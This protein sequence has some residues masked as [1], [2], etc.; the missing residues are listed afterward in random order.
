MAPNSS[1]WAYDIL[2]AS[3]PL[4][5][6]STEPLT[7]NLGLALWGMDPII[8]ANFALIDEN[9][10]GGGGTSVYVNGSIVNNPN[11]NGTIPAA[12]SG[13]TNVTW[14][15]DGSGNVSAYL[16]ALILNPSGSQT[17]NDSPTSSF[18]EQ[19]IITRTGYPTEQLYLNGGYIQ[20]H[21]AYA[22]GAAF[23]S[24]SN[25]NFR[26]P[27]ITGAR[28]RG[29]QSSPS[30]IQSGDTIM[31][32]NTSGYAGTDY[33]GP[34]GSEGSPAFSLLVQA[35]ENWSNSAQ[36]SVVSIYT[37]AKGQQGEEPVLTLMCNTSPLRWCVGVNDIAPSS[38]FS[39]SNYDGGP[40]SAAI[41]YASGHSSPSNSL[42]VAGTVRADLGFTISGTAGSGD[43]LRGN[44]TAFVSSAIQIGDLP[45]SGSW[46]FAGT[47][48]GNFSITGNVTISGELIDGSGSAGTNGQIISSTG[49]A[50]KWINAPS[51]SSAWSSLTNPTTNLSLQM[52]ENTTTFTWSGSVNSNQT[53]WDAY[54]NFYLQTA[55]VSGIE[56]SPS[57]TL[58]A[59]YEIAG[60]SPAR[61]AY[62]DWV[63]QVVMSG[64]SVEGNSTLTLDHYGTTGVST[65]DV[66]SATL[67]KA[68]SELI[69][70]TETL[71]LN[72]YTSGINNSPSLVIAGS[73]E[74]ASTPTYAEDSW[75]IQNVIGTG[76]NGTST[77]TFTHSGTS[78]AAQI[79]IPAGSYS[80]PAL[81]IGGSTGLTNET[82][83]AYV[84]VSSHGG[85]QLCANGDLLQQVDWNFGTTICASGALGFA[86]SGSSAASPTT[87]CVGSGLSKTLSVG[88]NASDYGGS[89]LCNR[90][91]MCATSS[92][93]VDTGVTRVGAGIV[94]IGT[95]AAGSVA[96]TL[97][98]ASIAVD[99]A[100]VESGTINIAGS[101]YCQGTEGLTE[102]GTALT[103]I[104]T[105]GGIVTA[106]SDASDERL[107]EG[108][109]YTEGL[110]A[111][112]HISPKKFR[113]NKEGEKVTGLK[114]G[115]ENIGFYAQNVQQSIP[116]AVWL[117]K[118]EYL[119]LDDRAIIAALVNAIKTLNARIEYL[120]HKK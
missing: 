8:A 111:I 51:S 66:S 60:G 89:F 28:S 100:T 49:S 83:L 116:E 52:G 103:S 1:G 115:R 6:E 78:G 110:Q 34:I 11:F 77:L 86:S 113:W 54:G 35:T 87:V 17:I 106:T 7:S 5:F 38:S 80:T 63:F 10:G 74:S 2:N 97:E 25:T 57:F 44:G 93:T 104:T 36:G 62:D 55:S 96:G 102:T 107:K 70:G 32:I 64:G 56:N 19:I 24:H 65:F 75:T 40:A 117:G 48:S 109:D 67:F 73:Y 14:Q 16:D 33:S 76:V 71:G 92:T 119:A 114:H 59:V 43:Y 45:T 27:V 112:L 58:A 26:G 39:I 85:L 42:D 105:I 22:Q 23:F 46:A 29:T 9:G 3:A 13:S 41:G 69:L 108:V 82:G 101:Y 37:S 95:G 98:C 31:E 90:V 94:G 81:I 84:T 21:S 120:E 47:F 12:S 61:Y 91:G 4:Y 118:Q 79:E 30:S 68:N 99:G 50:V 88:A 18:P 15:T 53:M 20:S 72:S